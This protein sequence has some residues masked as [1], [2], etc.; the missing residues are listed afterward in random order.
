MTTLYIVRHGQSVANLEERFAGRSDFP[1]TDLGRRQAA[2]AAAYLKEHVKL[3]AVYASD[4]SRAWETGMII[5]R[6]QG[7]TPIADEGLREIWAGL[8]E[9]KKFSELEAEFPESYTLW[10]ENIG[11]A[12]CDGGESIEQ[13]R[14]R[15]WAAVTAIVKKHP[16]GHICIASH[17]AAIR[18]LEAEIRGLAPDEMKNY[19]WVGNASITTVVFDD[20]LHATITE[21]DNREPLGN[22]ASTLPANV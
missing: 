7:L 2:C 16:G 6:A 21:R 22:L 5:A 12:A 9:S 11:R 15:V 13:V 18:S 19:P 17:G 10:K 1:L 14:H 8:W 3:D 20:N 4:L